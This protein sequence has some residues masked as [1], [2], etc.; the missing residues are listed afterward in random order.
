MCFVRS[1]PFQK[2]FEIEPGLKGIILSGSPFSVN[3]ENAPMLILQLLLRKFRYWA[4]VMAHSLQQ[5]FLA[6]RIDKSNKR[7]FGRA[8]LTNPKRRYPV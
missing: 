1:F 5:K 7:E 8:K 4:F 3:E 6:G 2:S